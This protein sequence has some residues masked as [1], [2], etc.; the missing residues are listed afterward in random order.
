MRSM[1]ISPISQSL[2]YVP[3]GFLH[4]FKVTTN[5]PTFISVTLPKD[6]NNK[7]CCIE[8]CNKSNESVRFNNTKNSSIRT[9]RLCHYLLY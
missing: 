4:V 3:R 7:F 5:I 1:S 8:T 9:N 6:L 2:G